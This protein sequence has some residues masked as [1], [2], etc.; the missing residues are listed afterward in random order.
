MPLFSQFYSL[1]QGLHLEEQT[2]QMSPL[3][4]QAAGA[5]VGARCAL[6]GPCAGEVKAQQGR[7]QD[8]SFGDPSRHHFLHPLLAL[9]K[10]CHLLEEVV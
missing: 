5:V 9:Q 10:Q 8:S 3:W 7:G 6:R 1:L 2:G 4:V